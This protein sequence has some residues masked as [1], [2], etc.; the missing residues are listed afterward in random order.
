MN[1]LA[2]CVYVEE[3]AT[4]QEVKRERRPNNMNGQTKAVDIV[5][6][7]W[8]RWMKN[9][10]R[11]LG[12]QTV[13]VLGKVRIDG[14]DGAA[15]ANA[16]TVLPDGIMEVD[17]AIA[18]LGDIRKKV[19]KIAYIHY[20]NASEDTQRRCLRMSRYR[21]NL[22]LKEARF[23]VATYLGIPPSEKA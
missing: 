1:A 6:A 3:A 2:S 15:Q 8:G 20:P 17:A 13:S 5:L 19:L 16:P 11:V 21:W 14:I 9:A 12:W 10:D 7:E 4:P 23:F 18:K 22:L